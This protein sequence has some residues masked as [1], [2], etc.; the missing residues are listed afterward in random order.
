M[1]IIYQNTPDCQTLTTTTYLYGGAETSGERSIRF[2]LV[3]SSTQTIWRISLR[4]L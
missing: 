2:I 4:Q 1:K 3:E